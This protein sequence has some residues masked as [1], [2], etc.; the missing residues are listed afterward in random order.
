M[1]KKVTIHTKR[2]PCTSTVLKLQAWFA[3]L[4]RRGGDAS[5]A[6]L[7]TTIG[8]LLIGSPIS[9]QFFAAWRGLSFKDIL[10]RFSEAES[11]RTFSSHKEV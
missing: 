9:S 2:T 10:F 11:K 3:G 7:A 8:S 1:Y 4:Y 6:F 5:L